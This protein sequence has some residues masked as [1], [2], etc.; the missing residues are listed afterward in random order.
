MEAPSPLPESSVLV[1]QV[2]DRRS[3]RSYVGSCPAVADQ[4][5][6]ATLKA[7]V[8]RLSR[9]GPA[10][11]ARSL[12]AHPRTFELSVRAVVPAR[13]GPATELEVGDHYHAASPE[14]W[15]PCLGN[16]P[17]ATEALRLA[18]YES[19]RYAHAVMDRL[20]RADQRS[21]RARDRRASLT[22]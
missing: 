2:Y 6:R 18:Y 5:H 11:F 16:D 8:Q 1:Y 19:D 20:V 10:A 9:E 4:D 14:G 17:A 12:R 21:R 15:S 7:E 22:A 3:R 13:Q